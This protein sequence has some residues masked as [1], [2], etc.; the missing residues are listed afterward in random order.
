MDLL[1]HPFPPARRISLIERA[2]ASKPS[3]SSPHTSR[4]HPP[5]PQLRAIE[6]R[7]ALEHNLKNLDVDIPL[8]KLTVLC[9]VS[10]SGKTSLAL[11]TLYAEGQRRYIESFSA[12]AR[13][14][15]ARLEKP[16]FERLD[17]LPPTLAITR[18]DRSR[19]NRSTVGTTADLLEPLRVLFSLISLPSCPNCKGPIEAFSPSSMCDKLETFASRRA[20]LSIPITWNNK[21]ELAEQ[22]AH[23]Q[24]SGWTRFIVA[25]STI[26]LSDDRKELA[27]LFPKAGQAFVVF[28]RFRCS[29]PLEI[30]VRQSAELAFDHD[31]SHVTVFLERIDQSTADAAAH[32]SAQASS[33]QTTE[34]DG[35][36]FEVLRFSSELL[37]T[38]CELSIPFA[39]P[40]LFSFNSPLGACPKC[41]GF[42]ESS[43]I[44]MEKIVPDRSLSIRPKGLQQSAI[45]PWRTPAYLH[46]LEELLALASSENIDVDSPVDQLPKE[47]WKIIEHGST[48]HRFGGLDGFFQWL[49]RK[50]YKMHVRIFLNRWKSYKTCTVCFGERLSKNALAYHYQHKNFFQLTEL[51]IDQLIDLIGELS[52]SLGSFPSDKQVGIQ[53]ATAEVLSRLNYLHDVG[54]GYLTLSRTMHTLSGGE[55]QRVQLTNL[56]GSDLVDMLYVLDEPTVGLHPRDTERVAK[57]VRRLIDRGNTVVLIEHEPFL[58]EQADQVIEIGP[59]AGANGGR[60]CFCGPPE[61]LS[62]SDCL[63]AK[64]LFNPPPLPPKRPIDPKSLKQPWITLKKAQGRNLKVPELR[65]PLNCFC[66][67]I[68]VSG[69]GKS[70]LI[71]DTLVP[72]ILENLQEETQSPLPFQSLTGIDSIRRVIA[73][74]QTPI[75]KSIRS[76]AAT[77]LKILDEI[78]SIFGKLPAAKNQSLRDADFSFNSGKGRCQ[79]CEGLGFTLVDMQFMADIQLPC[80][81]C[82]GK[83]FQP[84]IL[85]IQYRN[86]SIAD[87]LEMS[88]DQAE[89]FFRGEKKLLQKLQ[90][91]RDIGLGYLPI[92][93]SL[94]TLSAGEMM[95]LKL[96]SYLDDP[97][98]SLIVMDEPT[99]GLHFQDV[100]RLV[101]CI[102]LL[103]ERKNSVIAIEHN[104]ALIAASDYSIEL[105][106]GAG[107]NGGEITFQGPWNPSQ[108]N[109]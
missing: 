3:N 68:G 99:T 38:S 77:Y 104:E 10:G 89:A 12:Y 39:E 33:T 72:A 87:V 80:G 28:D 66:T 23:W 78:R 86:K 96:A 20:I 62:K 15:L 83:R 22:L 107:P 108:S 48:K 26:E 76:C 54:L 7:G 70:S 9:G 71:L 36:P 105:G 82:R 41:A 1:R 58:L 56:L 94:S 31:H 45:A 16:K 59:Q 69:A 5:A 37:C 74:D 93:Q 51:S 97:S 27:K 101:Q 43:E 92:G 53:R 60:V 85:D 42:G 14:F 35:K 75:A 11:D 50:K 55:A 63:T 32:N 25:G 95:R 13:Q 100:E 106:P 40:R 4:L 102:Q 49:E 46:E 8:H 65:I 30:S 17:H 6:L 109:R 90:P 18:S 44:D 98:G 79:T 67:V 91:L 34:I 21:T 88:A 2:L 64:Y 73:I 57:A 47:A 103:V 29:S 52:R 19:N 61:K 84:H 24:S 81:E